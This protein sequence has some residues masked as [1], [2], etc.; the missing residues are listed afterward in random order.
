MFI[1]V[2]NNNAE[3]KYYDKVL[4]GEGVSSGDELLE[5]TLKSLAAF[6]RLT[7]KQVLQNHN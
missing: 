1:N 2:I 7:Y 5:D 6:H 3:E 4:C